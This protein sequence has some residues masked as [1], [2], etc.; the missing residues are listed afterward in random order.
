MRLRDGLG[1]LGALLTAGC[2][3]IQA[4]LTTDPALGHTEQ[5]TRMTRDCVPIILGFSYGTLSA[6]QALRDPVPLIDAPDDV[7]TFNKPITKIK[8]VALHDYQF[9]FIGARC[10]EVY[11]E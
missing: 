4:E 8:T 1:L 10:V 9:W 2:L 11:G 5:A 6:A 3:N 7:N